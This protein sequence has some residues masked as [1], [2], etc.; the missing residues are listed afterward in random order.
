VTIPALAR[1]VLNTDATGY[2][3]LMT[4]TGIGSLTAALLIAFSG[5]SRPAFVPLGALVL[6]MALVAAAFINVY[7]FALVALLFVGFGAIG[8]AATANTTIQLAVPDELRGRVI[9]VYTTVFVG[10]TPIGGLLMGWIASAISVEASLLVG[11][12]GCLVVGT[13]SLAWL[14]RIR[15]GAL[16]RPSVLAI[17]EPAGGSPTTGTG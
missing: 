3:F 6:G 13:L 16:L 14:R 15:G 11:G 8:M 17:R 7:A 9:S 10:S 5:R 4:A 12:V 1:E 2:G